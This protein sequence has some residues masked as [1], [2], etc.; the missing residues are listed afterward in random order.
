MPTEPSMKKQGRK[1]PGLYLKL[2]KAGLHHHGDAQPKYCRYGQKPSFVSIV[3]R[4]LKLWP[5][6]NPQTAYEIDGVMFSVKDIRKLVVVSIIG[7]LAVFCGQSLLNFTWISM[8]VFWKPI[9]W[10]RPHFSMPRFRFPGWWAMVSGV[11]CPDVGPSHVFFI[12]KQFVDDHKEQQNLK[13]FG[14]S[15]GQLVK[16]FQWGLWAQFEL[17]R[18][19]AISSHFSWWDIYGFRNEKDFARNY[20]SPSLATLASFGDSANDLSLCFSRL[21]MLEDN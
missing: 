10:F 20:Y 6:I 4:L 3:A 2:R 12:S 19:L 7:A 1:I 16:R 11:V 9:P 14:Y 8:L 15:N 13:S 21:V 17:E 5:M 18:F